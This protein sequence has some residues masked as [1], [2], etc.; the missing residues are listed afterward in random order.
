VLARVVEA[1]G[2]PTVTVTMMPVLSE[3]YRASRVLGAQ[4]PFGHSFG[5]AHDEAMQ[6]RTLR[7]ALGLLVSAAK[8]ETRLD[9]EDTWP[10]DPKEAY[11]SW[12]PSEP[13]PIVAHSIDMIRKARRDAARKDSRGT[14]ESHSW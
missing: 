9:V 4:F 7:A 14:S 11:K 3:K 10:G 8:P 1:S 5:V 12:Q 13:S 6:T 2:I